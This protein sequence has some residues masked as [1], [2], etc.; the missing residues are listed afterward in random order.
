M[1]TGTKD[2]RPSLIWNNFLK[3]F[4]DQISR[5]LLQKDILIYQ[6][7][8]VLKLLLL[9]NKINSAFIKLLGKGPSLP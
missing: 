4:F 6:L 1:I 7:L 5:G 8:I 3:M 9:S 2:I